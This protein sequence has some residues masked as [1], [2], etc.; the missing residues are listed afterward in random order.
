MTHAKHRI[1]LL[2]GDGIGQEVC[3]SAV[4]VLDVLARRHG[5]ELVWTEFPWGCDYYLQTGSM[6][7]PDALETLAPYDAIL[8]GAV[9]SPKVKDLVSLWG[10]LIPI[11][12]RFDQYVNLRP[13]RSLRV[14]PSALR[15]SEPIDFL[16]V[17]ENSEGEYSEAG[18]R[19]FAGTPRELAIQESIFSR[20]GIERIV[21]FAAVAA[22]ERKGKLVSATK[23][24]GIIHT[25]PFWDEVAQR[26]RRVAASLL[27]S[28]TST[29][30]RLG[31]SSHLKAWMSLSPQ[32]SS[33]TF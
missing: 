17:R 31:S 5:F 4:R 19:L 23:S 27:T 10:L 26:W 29:R 6:M 3:E 20:I 11:R 24:N 14:V 9:G 30:W 22:L 7:A 12:R 2:P 16:I 18:G 28:N 32:I 33:E 15:S 13:V 8:L 1:A 21:N 25:M